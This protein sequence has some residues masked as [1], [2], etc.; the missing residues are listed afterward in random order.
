[1]TN[2]SSNITP[3]D[4]NILIFSKS[5]IEDVG[6]IMKGLNFVGN[7]I[8]GVIKKIPE[9]QQAWLAKTINKVLMTVIKTNLKT[10]SKGKANATP[11]K[12]TYK[13]MVTASG[14]GFGFFGELGFAADL[15][16]FTN[17][18]MRSVLDIARSHGEDVNAIE[19]QLACLEVFALGGNTK[20]DDGLETSYYAT[21]LAL[22]A[23]VK[24]ASV[25]IAANGTTKIVENVLISTNP[26]AKLV[27][28][29]A[30]RYGVQV[31][32][33]FAAELVPVVGAVGGGAINLIFMNH[34]QNVATAHFAI[35]SLERK[36]GNDFIRGEYEKI[37]V[38]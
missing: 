24:E 28:S 13:A 34:F 18:L 11:L 10:M 8:E 30:S 2:L 16:I 9:K 25:Y 12:K 20:N 6:V 23:A 5:K 19:T 17:L 15:G 32:E 31:T 37:K 35:R 27:A 29:I 22:S 33:K 14:I 26:I 38:N 1:M 21:R 3:E 36:Y 4:L 7:S